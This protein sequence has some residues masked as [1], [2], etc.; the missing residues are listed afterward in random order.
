MNAGPPHGA[1][2]SP[3]LEKQTYFTSKAFKRVLECTNHE[4]IHV[5]IRF[6]AEGWQTLAGRERISTLLSDFRHQAPSTANIPP[7]W[8]SCPTPSLHPLALP[9]SVF[10]GPA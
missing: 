10:Q 1:I 7:S 5:V 4:L 3:L 2:L 8:T 9:A 6:A